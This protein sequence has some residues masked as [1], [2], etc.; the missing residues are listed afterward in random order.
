M[1]IPKED[2]IKFIK[3]NP[4]LTAKELMQK[5]GVSKSVIDRLKR[6]AG[7][8]K[9]KEKKENADRA[10]KRIFEMLNHE[11]RDV[12][13]MAHD[14]K[15]SAN[16]VRNHLYQMKSDGLVKFKKSRD[17]SL[18]LWS[19]AKEEKRIYMHSLPMTRMPDYF[20]NQQ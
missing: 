1:T 3:R 6:Q 4:E 8:S 9:R 5:L 11:S 19:I 17:S 16:D 13:S 10:K 20:T 15:M 14:L 7:V 2:R 12:N 18:G